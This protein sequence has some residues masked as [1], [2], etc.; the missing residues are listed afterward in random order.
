MSTTATIPTKYWHALADG[1]V[2][3]DVCP[4]ACKLHDGQRGLC[5]VRAREGDA[6]R[7]HHVRPLE[8]LL[9]R[10]DR[11]EAAEPLPARLVGAVVRH[12]GLQPR[13]PLLPELGH[14][15]VARRS[16]RSPTPRRPRRSRP[17]RRV[18]RLPQRRVHLQRPGDLHGVRDRRRRRVPR[19]SASRR[20]PSPP[21]TCARSRAR[22]F[23]AHMD[24]ANVD[25]KAFT[26]DFYRPHLRRP[27]RRRCSTRS[28][29]SCTRP[30]CGSRSPTLLIPGRNDSDAEL[31]EM[32]RWVV[33]HLG[34]DVPMHFTAFHPDFK[35]TRPAA[36]RRRRRSRGRARSRS[37]NGVRYAYT[38]NV[39]DPAGGS[40]YCTTCG[41]RV[42]ER[43][44]YVLGDYRLT[45]DGRCG[46][47]GTPV[48]GRFDGPA[49]TL[50]GTAPARAARGLRGGPGSAGSDERRRD[51]AADPA[52]VARRPLL[53]RRPRD[54]RRATS[55]RT[56][57]DGAAAPGSP[58][59]PR[60]R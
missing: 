8:R 16:T 23:Y 60:R 48:P 41:T 19:A 43:D 40:T 18:A 56:C 59:R 37:R 6:S 31:D 21:A 44:W 32:T 20:S 7:A 17:R 54:A 11:E 13:V 10:S 33:E 53:P 12:R 9:R 29:T 49:G 51:G 36:R 39:H 55:T 22:E 24:A 34:P 4:R 42:I 28:S 30:T 46:S 1:R 26:E 47:C 58:R 50:G 15:E 2:Q 45:D 38:G 35:M 5:F 3:C 14:L 52:A 25:L 27:P 57:R